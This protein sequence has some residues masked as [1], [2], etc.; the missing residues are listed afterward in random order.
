MKRKKVLFL[1]LSGLLGIA[2]LGFSRSGLPAG[3]TPETYYT[4]W[5]VV[6]GDTLKLENDEKVHL[7]GI[8]APDFYLSRKV[9]DEARRTREK[10]QSLRVRG[11]MAKDFTRE[12]VQG[13]KVRL[14][15]DQDPRNKRGELAAYVYLEDGTFLNAELVR[16]GYAK[17]VSAE[18]NLRY[19]ESL[20]KIE[21]EARAEKRGLWQY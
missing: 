9:Y 7:L 1:I 3:Y 11:R 8:D 20:K 14:E 10:M 6:D 12:L 18:P 13:K 17:A 16:Q 19:D 21:E 2:S 5:R 15:F 4:V